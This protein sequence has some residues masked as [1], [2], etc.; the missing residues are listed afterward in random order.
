M[1][2]RLKMLAVLVLAIPS[3]VVLGAQAKDQSTGGNTPSKSQSKIKIQPQGGPTTPVPAAPPVQTG[4]PQITAEGNAPRSVKVTELPEVVVRHDFIDYVEIGC[5]VLLTIIGYFGIRYAKRTLADIKRQADTMDTYANESRTNV[6][7]ASAIAKDAADAAKKSADAALLNAEAIVNAERPWVMVQV[8]PKPGTNAAHT[9]FNF[10][11]FNYG[12]TP[13]HIIE[14]TKP[15]V[16]CCKDPAKDLPV[17]PAYGTSDTESVFL[18]PRDSM[19][20]ASV[21]PAWERREASL[22]GKNI[23]PNGDLVML[24][25]GQISYI[26][27]VSG[28]TY[29]TAYCFL[30]KRFEFSD[31]GGSMVRVGPPDYNAYS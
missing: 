22:E 8:H 31:M 23:F 25:Y 16:D 28:K 14:R 17:P 29:R 3:Y 19:P 7:R 11:L 18:A 24:V 2:N 10:S 4:S 20:L 6:E 30:H 21:D 12:K 13:A 1:D 15:K 26:D 9:I 27:G 5:S